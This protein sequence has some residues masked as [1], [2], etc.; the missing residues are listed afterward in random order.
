M[1]DKQKAV[2]AWIVFGLILTSAIAQLIYNLVTQA[3]EAGLIEIGSDIAWNLGPVVF[4][5]V[6][7]IIVSRQPRNVIGLLLMLPALVFAISPENYFASRFPTAPT[8]PNLLIYAT[9]WISGWSWLLLIM[10]ILF[11]LVLFPTGKPFTPRWRWPIYLGL[12]MS[13]VFILLGTF[14]EEFSVENPG[15]SITNPIGFMPVEW[16]DKYLAT[17]WFMLMPVL[18]ILCASALF[19]RFRRGGLVEREQI[20]WLLYAGVLFAAVY[21]TGFLND[22]LSDNPLWMMLLGFTLW[23]IPAAIG[24]AILRYHL[25]DIDIIIRRTLQY[26]L[27]TAVLLAVYFGLVLLAQAVFVAITGQESP[28]AIVVSTLVIAALFNPLRRRIQSFIDRRF[29]RS[30]YDAELTL[31]QFAQTARDEVELERITSE[32]VRSVQETMQPESLGLWLVPTISKTPLDE[33]GYGAAK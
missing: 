1:N 16:W 8:E 9:L 14:V 6:G 20:K 11:V 10:P 24:I 25:F 15:W 33:A 29:Y 17:P 26:G 22:T 23:T 30:S 13:L 28:I 21:G 19:V 7:A 3:G 18:T 4:G 2:A 27:L 32:L 5:L 12:A 31:R